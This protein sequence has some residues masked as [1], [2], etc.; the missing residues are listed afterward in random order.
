MRAFRERRDSQFYLSALSYAQSLLGEGKP[1]QALL[2]INK[3][4]MAELETEDVLVTWPPAY[5]AVVWI[6]ER[7]RGDREC[8]LG[9]PVRHYQHLATR[10]SGPRGGIR[11]LRAWACFYLAETFAPEY[12]RDL[13]QLQKEKLTIPSFQSVLSAIDRFGWDGE[14]N[15]LRGTFSSLRDR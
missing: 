13:E 4:F 3:S 9:N 14:G 5:Q 1:A 8:F 12:E 15:V 11:T 2:Q 7:Y 10:M 6:I